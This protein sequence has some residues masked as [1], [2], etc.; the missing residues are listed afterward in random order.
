MKTV[1]IVPMKLNNR[2]LPQ[3]NTKSFTNGKPLCCY[4]LSTLLTVEGVDEVYVYCSNPDIQ[5]FIPEG[6]KYLRR[7]ESLDQDTTKMNEV[8]QCFAKD[9][10]ADIYVMTHTTA[11]FISKGSIEKGLNAVKSGE[12]DS[13]FAAKKLQDFLWKDGIPFNYE[14]DNIPRT[15]DLPP[16]YEE[17]SGFYIYKADVITKL[18][19][20]IGNH[21]FIVEV[22][23]IESVDID[24]SEDFMIADAIFNHLF[25]NKQ[26]NSNE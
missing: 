8:L 23:E 5:E 4:I 12:Y 18:N 3:K 22:G 13:S 15:Q 25:A 11:P 14:L 1:A 2:R 7:S 19:R 26:E 17:T 16:I 20:R 21:P 6:V 10:P 9:I 24:E